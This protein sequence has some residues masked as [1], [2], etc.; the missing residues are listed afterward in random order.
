MAQGSSERASSLEE[1]SASLQEMASMT[2]Q[3]A[4]NSR[5]ANESAC[6]GGEAMG[7]MSRAIKDIK[8][9]SDQTARIVKTIDEIAFQTNLLALN[10]A[11]EAARAGEAGKGFAVVAEE[12]RNLAQ[13]SADSAKNTAALIEESQR[14]AGHG[15]AVSEEVEGLLKQVTALIAKVSSAS[16]EQSKGIEQVSNAVTL[17][18]KATQANAANAEETA[19]ASEELNAQA[20]ELNEQVNVLLAILEGETRGRATA[21]AAPIQPGAR[22]HEFRGPNG[23]GKRTLTVLEGPRPANRIAHLVAPPKSD[24]PSRAFPLNDD[25]LKGF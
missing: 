21:A 3:T 5:Q 18:D 24:R 15:V 19:S 11:V 6:K 12:V 23:N 22:P 14:N 1:T 8:T 4:D 9:S 13:R 10:A 7:R 25:D 17:M 16:G 20:R 2:T